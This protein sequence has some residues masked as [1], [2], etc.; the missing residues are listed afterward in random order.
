MGVLFLVIF[1][2]GVVLCVVCVCLWWV[3]LLRLDFPQGGGCRGQGWVG[4]PAVLLSLFFTSLVA[5]PSSREVWSVRL[6][7][8]SFALK[9]K[10]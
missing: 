3:I 7:G 5:L 8:L 4:G 6:R 1:L 9:E 2:M 10:S